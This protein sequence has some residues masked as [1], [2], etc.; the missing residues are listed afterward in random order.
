MQCG[1]Q[2]VYGLIYGAAAASE[3]PADADPRTFRE[4]QEQDYSHPAWFCSDFCSDLNPWYN[5][6]GV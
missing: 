1:Q 4:W 6:D 5:N 3:A 2:K